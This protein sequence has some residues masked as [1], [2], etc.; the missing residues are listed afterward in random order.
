MRCFWDPKRRIFRPCRLLGKSP[1]RPLLG[2]G[3]SA[4]PPLGGCEHAAHAALRARNLDV[5]VARITREETPALRRPAFL[6]LPDP[7]GTAPRVDDKAVGMERMRACPQRACTV[8]G[9]L[10][11]A[12]RGTSAERTRRATME[13]QGGHEDED[14]RPVIA[15]NP[16]A[17]QVVAPRPALALLGL[18]KRAHRVP[19]GQTHF[20]RCGLLLVLLLLL[21]AS[22]LASRVRLISAKREKACR[23]AVL[24]R[25]WAGRRRA[26]VWMVPGPSHGVHA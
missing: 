6:P 14:G 3:P 17:A 15:L 25:Q 9:G 23:G 18:D 19:S 13:E 2:G 11:A 22:A 4:I 10:R 26:R 12:C 21:F 8:T 7:G 20:F 24:M 1:V 5:G 16:Y